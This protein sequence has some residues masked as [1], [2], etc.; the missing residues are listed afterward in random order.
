MDAFILLPERCDMDP[1]TESNSA[2]EAAGKALE[3]IH[4]Y[5][6]LQIEAQQRQRMAI[7]DYIFQG[8]P[9]TPQMAA[10][11]ASLL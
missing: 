8:K 5:G 2:D 1:Q 4:Q 7:K 10:M 11:I 3:E 6:M 9:I